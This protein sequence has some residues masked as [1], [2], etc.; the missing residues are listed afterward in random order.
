MT[1]WIDKW[2]NLFTFLGLIL[3]LLTFLGVI[4]NKKI[5]NR[6]NKKNFKT[7]RMPENYSDLTRI[8]EKLSDYLADFDNNK[9]EIKT[10]ISKVSP[11]LKS[12]KKSLNSN[13]NENLVLLKSSIKKIDSWK[14]EGEKIVW[15]KKFIYG[16]K[17]MTEKLVNEVDIKLTRLITDI[18]NISKDNKK[19]L[20]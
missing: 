16:E 13:E 17:N 7:N 10:E 8:S 11:I 19:N 2:A 5:L 4:W 18:D 14:Y 12:L 15:Y 3:T 20:L 9:K 1:S 6:L